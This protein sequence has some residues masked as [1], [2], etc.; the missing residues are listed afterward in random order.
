MSVLLSRVLPVQ[1]RIEKEGRKKK[2][3]ARRN[4]SRRIKKKKKKNHKVVDDRYLRMYTLVP[5]FSGIRE[6]FER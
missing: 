5:L 2:T 3:M 1:V 6:I 4:L